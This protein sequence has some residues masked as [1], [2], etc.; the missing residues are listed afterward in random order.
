MRRNPAAHH[1]AIDEPLPIPVLN[2]L[3]SQG[4]G[5][6]PPVEDDHQRTPQSNDASGGNTVDAFAVTHARCLLRTFPLS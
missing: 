6:S 5:L 1:G 3:C 4:D 2:V